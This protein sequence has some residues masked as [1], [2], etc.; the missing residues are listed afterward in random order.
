MCDAPLITHGVSGSSYQFYDYQ[1]IHEE[2]NLFSYLTTIGNILY[3]DDK[4]A[5]LTP[6]NATYIGSKT[7]G[8]SEMTLSLSES[9]VDVSGLTTKSKQAV[10]GS[11][12]LAIG[13]PEV[14][15]ISTTGKVDYARE[16]TNTE[17]FTKTYSKSDDLLC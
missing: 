7:E 8:T 4:Q 3:Y 5:V 15:G 13:A 16:L 2:G 14:T 11:L 6:E 12:T 10:N 17:S 1:P 9:T